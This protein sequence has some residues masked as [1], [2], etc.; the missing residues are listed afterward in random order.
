MV[1]R[2]SAIGSFPYEPF[3]VIELG[4]RECFNQER[5]QRGDGHIEGSAVDD[6]AQVSIFLCWIDPK[7]ARRLVG[8]LDGETADERASVIL[9]CFGERSEHGDEARGF[10]AVGDK[11]VRDLVWRRPRQRSDDGDRD[12]RVVPQEDPRG[13]DK[14]DPK[15]Q[16]DEPL[17][18]S[19]RG[20][21]LLR[22][23][24]GAWARLVHLLLLRPGD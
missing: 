15:K 22:G 13:W 23:C 10:G 7:L 12:S 24:F 8:V 18:T 3:H 1:P 11:V 14:H 2:A 17:G 4:L 19:P 21:A 5:A 16:E 20:L 6:D 9:R